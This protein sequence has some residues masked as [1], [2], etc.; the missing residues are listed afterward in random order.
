MNHLRSRIST[1]LAGSV[2]WL[3][4]ISL[5]PLPHATR[6]ALPFVAGLLPPPNQPAGSLRPVDLTA[7]ARVTPSCTAATA[8]VVLRKDVFPIGRAE[9]WS[10]TSVAEAQAWLD[11]HVALVGAPRACYQIPATTGIVCPT[12]PTKP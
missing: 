10:C 2:I 8:L 12:P 5:A 6:L 11:Y 7:W 1:A 9:A 3:L 4:L